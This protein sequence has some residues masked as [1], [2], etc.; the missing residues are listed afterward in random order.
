M[1]ELAKLIEI[2]VGGKIYRY[3]LDKNHLSEKLPSLN[4]KVFETKATL[5]NDILSRGVAEINVREDLLADLWS[6][7]KLRI[8]LGIDPTGFDLTLGHAVV[9]RKLK[10]FQEAGHQIVL[11]IGNFTAQIGDP[12]GKSQT[13]KILTKEEVMKNAQ[14]YLD[15]AAKILDINKIEI[16]YN[17]DWLENMTFAE[18]LK[19]AGN[20]TVAQMLERDMFQERI[21]NDKEI[22]LVEFMY[23]LMQG[24]DS[25]PLKADVE[26]GGTDQL[27]NMMCARP[28]QKSL[29]LK[30]QNVLTVP[31]LVGLD[32]KEK[33][34]KSL[35][36]Y[37]AILDT[38]KEMYGKTMSIPDDLII[39]YFELATE[40]STAEI[41]KIEKELHNG[42][43][44]RNV[45]AKLAFAITKLYHGEQEAMKAAKEFD[46][47][48]K[49]GGLPDNIPEWKM[50]NLS[51]TVLEKSGIGD[52]KLKII[53]VLVALGFCASKG[54][55]RRAIE[56]GGVRIEGEKVESI[57]TELSL[58]EGEK[59]LLQLG[60]RKFV[61]LK[62]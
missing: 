11:L 56:G 40:V 16:V 41:K 23:P 48:F 2:T 32:G 6:G 53:D 50:E 42:A 27:F 4:R 39:N 54:E 44:P 45:K 12:T 7:R 43:N 28:I 29:G 3:V 37:I 51:S 26:V 60:K 31:I 5:V 22:N 59:K 21:R 57:E 46:E 55:A 61:W 62:S 52:E 36:N 18:V 38:P 19:L 33:M 25:V 34:S 47:I 9:L 10:Q 14:T 13:R 30:P 17:A 1:D 49:K 20:F 35:G 8:K 24:Y 58:S 15:Q